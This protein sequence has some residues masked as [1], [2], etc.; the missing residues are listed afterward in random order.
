MA[1]TKQPA[2]LAKRRPTIKVL[3]ENDK[4]QVIDEVWRPGEMSPDEFLPGLCASLGHRWRRLGAHFADGTPAARTQKKGQ[5][6]I[7]L[8]KSELIL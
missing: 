7:P 1:P 5:T 8:P 4:V 2:N 6:G 3:G